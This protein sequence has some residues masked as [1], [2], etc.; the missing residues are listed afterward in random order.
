MAPTKI[1][2][3]CILQECR[4]KT[5]NMTYFPYLLNNI[6]Q[7]VG[8]WICR[9]RELCHRWRHDTTTAL[10]TLPVHWITAFVSERCPLPTGIPTCKQ[11]DGSFSHIEC[12]FWRCKTFQ[13]V[14]ERIICSVIGCLYNSWRMY[15]D[16]RDYKYVRNTTKGSSTED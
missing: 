8:W 7:K 12:D 6:P 3:Q 15:S 11:R 4:H 16:H 2:L 9:R 13:W 10:T 14:T 1:R 5:W